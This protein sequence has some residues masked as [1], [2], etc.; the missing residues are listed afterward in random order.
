MLLRDSH[1]HGN[2]SAVLS[3]PASK[4]A[5]QNDIQNVLAELGSLGIEAQMGSVL[6]SHKPTI[7]SNNGG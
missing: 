6:V 7:N 5:L 3:I 1:V 2:D 4:E